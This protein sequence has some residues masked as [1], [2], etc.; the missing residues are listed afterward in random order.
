MESPILN[1]KKVGLHLKSTQSLKLKFQS[2]GIITIFLVF[3]VLATNNSFDIFSYNADVL[4][5]TLTFLVLI[6]GVFCLL[7]TDSK[8]F[9]VGSIGLAITDDMDSHKTLSMSLKQ[10]TIM[11][12][13]EKRKYQKNDITELKLK[14]ISF[15]DSL[16]KKTEI[17]DENDS[18]VFKTLIIGEKSRIKISLRSQ[19]EKNIFVYLPVFDFFDNIIDGGINAL[20]GKSRRTFLDFVIRNFS[21]NG[22]TFRYEN[23]RKRYIEWLNIKKTNSDNYLAMNQT[24]NLSEFL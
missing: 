21:K 19:N 22:E 6:I 8:N 11:I 17:I 20:Y 3:L 5:K 24:Y 1:I 14:P 13:K 23:L 7:F 15:V 12:E 9:K 16:L 4:M 10:N 18:N 2:I